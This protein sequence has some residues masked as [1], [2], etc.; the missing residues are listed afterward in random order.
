MLI[1]LRE[2]LQPTTQIIVAAPD[3]GRSECSHSVTTDRPLQIQQLA[4]DR[5]AIDGTPVDCV[6]IALST[7]AKDVDAVVSGINAGANLGIDLLVSGTFAAA[8]EAAILGKPALAISHYRHPEVP[9]TWQHVGR[10]LTPVWQRWTTHLATV[11]QWQSIAPLWNVN[12]PAIDPSIE[13]VEVVECGVDPTPHERQAQ[14]LEGVFHSKSDFHNRGRI[15][16]G[17]VEHCFA[18]KITISRIRSLGL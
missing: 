2:S 1:A 11:D 5:Y 4:E 18:G 8:R 14:I 9:K 3:R 7:F 17:D 13:S 12:L 16:G 6:R 15:P 10:W